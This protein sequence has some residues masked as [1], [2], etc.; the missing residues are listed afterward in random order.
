MLTVHANASGECKHGY[1][2]H[3]R[4][5]GLIVS[6]IAIQNYRLKFQ[7][8]AVAPHKCQTAVFLH[9]KL[10]VQYFCVFWRYVILALLL[11]D[12]QIR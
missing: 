9:S 11:D 3:K 6:G 8:A 1:L 4:I 10:I 7:L 2:L 12:N 5:L